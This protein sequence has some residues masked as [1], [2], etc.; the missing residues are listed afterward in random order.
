M[1][2]TSTRSFDLRNLGIR[3]TTALVF[4]VFFLTLLALGDRPWAKGVFLGLM[5]LGVAGGAREL[6]LMARKAGHAPSA[7]VATLVG[8]GI[9]LHF[10]LG[11]SLGRVEDPLP[12]WLVLI[13]GAALI[14]FGHLLFAK[15]PLQEALTSQAVTWMAAL[16]LGLGL[17]FMV[18]LFQYGDTTLPNT[19]GRLIFALFFITWLGDTAAYFVGT[20]WGKHPLAK[21]V[22]PKKSWEGFFGNFGG[23]LLAAFVVQRWVCTDWTLLDALF[24]GSILAVVGPLGD[25]VES[26]WKRSVGVKDSNMGLG[27]P[28]HGGMLDRL[29]SLIFAAPAL[30]AYVHFVHGLQ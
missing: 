21:R 19:G 3:V 17:G 12:L 1:T 23:N 4:A 18:K 7:F 27:I 16:Y 11:P 20:R 13:L 24:L 15:N 10:H 14:H 5:A 30:Y 6:C 8:W 22:S 28:G 9:L 25:L 2:P 29:D 26:T